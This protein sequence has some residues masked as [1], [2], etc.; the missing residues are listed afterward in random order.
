VKAV[1]VYNCNPA[2]VAPNHNEVVRGL[3]TRVICSP[4]STNSSSLTRPITQTLF[5]LPRRFFEQKELVKSYGHYYLQMSHQAIAPMGE[6]RSNVET[7]R[8][9]AL[10]MGFDDACFQSRLKR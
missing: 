6:A 5:C 3:Q 7:F 4:L 10:R 8:A 1:F 9:L 2:A